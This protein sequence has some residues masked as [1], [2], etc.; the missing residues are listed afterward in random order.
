[1]DNSTAEYWR[2]RA[3]KA[4]ARAEALQ[5][6]LE[7]S[8]RMYGEYELR[9]AAAFEAACK[10]YESRLMAQFG[11]VAP[12]SSNKKASPAEPEGSPPK[13]NRVDRAAG[14]G[15]PATQTSKP[16]RAPPVPPS[17][18]FGAFGR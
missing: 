2:S 12:P 8:E 15:Q 6:A 7:S 4:E 13:P 10:S 11:A 9:A 18:A 14:G 1:M 17:G 3:L 16:R 5:A